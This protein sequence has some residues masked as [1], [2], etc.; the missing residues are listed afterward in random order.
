MMNIEG[1]TFSV[2]ALMT[3]E[4]T[5]PSIQIVSDA[6]ETIQ[7]AKRVKDDLARKR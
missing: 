4:G 6:I 3:D 2:V 5:T 1:S 7:K